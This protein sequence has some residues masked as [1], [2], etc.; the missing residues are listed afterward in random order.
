MSNLRSTFQT[1][2]RSAADDARAA[3]LKNAALAAA[4]AAATVI[5]TESYSLLLSAFWQHRVRNR[6]CQC[7]LRLNN[8]RGKSRSYVQGDYLGFNTGNGEKP[9]YRQFRC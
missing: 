4:A 5:I 1:L 7:S 6:H 2:S 8:W 9:S 3:V